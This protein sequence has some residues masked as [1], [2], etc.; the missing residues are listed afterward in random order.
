MTHKSWRNEQIPTSL[1]C[2]ACGGRL[3]TDSVRVD[4]LRVGS[5][6]YKA[7]A[8]IGLSASFRCSSGCEVSIG[9]RGEVA[10]RFEELLTQERMARSVI[11]TPLGSDDPGDPGVDL[12]L[13]RDADAA[14]REVE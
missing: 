12:E 6:R 13:V 14:M 7:G 10:R 2:P 1:I 8:D 4:N 3:S 9:V 11:P 5:D